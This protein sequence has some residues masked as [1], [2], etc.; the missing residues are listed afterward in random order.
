MV[1]VPQ[2]AVARQEVI[3][4]VEYIDETDFSGDENDWEEEVFEIVEEVFPRQRSHWTVA[5]HEVGIGVP[6]LPSSSSSSSSSS[7]ISFRSDVRSVENDEI[8]KPSQQQQ[9]SLSFRGEGIPFSSQT[10]SEDFE[11]RLQRQ[12]DLIESTF[13][14]RRASLIKSRSA[15]PYMLRSNSMD[16]STAHVTPPNRK[17]LLKERSFVRRPKSYWYSDSDDDGDE[18]T[19]FAFTGDETFQAHLKIALGGE[20]TLAKPPESDDDQSS[21]FST[22]SGDTNP[23][24]APYT[25]REYMYAICTGVL[26]SFNAG[27]VN[28]TCL[29]G[30]LTESKRK[31]NVT[32]H[33]GTLTLSATSLSAGD[34]P[35]FS[36]YTSMMFCF[37]LGSYIAGLLTPNAKKFRI[38]PTY[39]PTFLIGAALLG[40]SSILAAIE[41]NDNVIFYLASAANGIQNGMSSLYSANLIRS[42]GVTGTVTDIGI[43][44]GQMLRGNKKN[45]WN[46]VVLLCLFMSFWTGGFVSFYATNKF[47][48]FSL[49]VNA[50]LYFLIG[51]SLIFFLTLELDVSVG[52]AIF[53]SWQ[54]RRALEQLRK[55]AF[56]ESQRSGLK[57]D[58][59]SSREAQMDMLFDRMD[60]NRS[61]TIDIHELHSALKLAGVRIT[62]RETMQ[63][64]KKADKNGDGEL[65]REEWRSIALLCHERHERERASR[66]L[67]GGI[68]MLSSD[69]DSSSRSGSSGDQDNHVYE[70][71]DART[72]NTS[73]DRFDNETNSNCQLKET[74]SEDM[75]ENENDSNSQLKTSS[76]EDRFDNE[77]IS[78]LRLQTSSSEDG[79]DNEN[80]SKH[81]LKTRSSKDGC[82]NEIIKENQLVQRSIVDDRLNEKSIEKTSSVDRFSNESG[83]ADPSFNETNGSN[84]VDIAHLRE[85]QLELAISEDRSD[86]EKKDDRGNELNK[87]S[88]DDQFDDNNSKGDNGAVPFYELPNFALD[89]NLSQ[90]GAKPTI[91]FQTRLLQLKEY[92]VKH[93]DF[94]VTPN[95]EFD[96]GFFVWFM[97]VTSEFSKKKHGEGDMSDDLFGELQK[98]GFR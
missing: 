15:G 36:F 87:S 28:G 23:L 27:Y 86:I 41:A 2:T 18:S 44:L 57:G 39:G 4:V 40:A 69:N 35:E 97:F 91:S 79:F 72:E 14:P 73:E 94:E 80:N 53:G 50:G 20:E 17:S 42:T 60:S 38:E 34:I 54:W 47:T 21:L 32:S 7:L 75:F 70:D 43:F 49:L 45:T 67:I 30:L 46:L 61:G 25:R 33:A 1:V 63:M 6:P 31:V 48:Q 64:I 88:C 11:D 92:K 93:G 85:G 9:E 51:A 81:H 37:M 76:S 55:D 29:T 98:I 13:K 16:D 96:E 65:S 77:C 52:A 84:L 90:Q 12:S 26:L 83:S 3:E 71:D 10:D 5:A 56:S 74:H 8:E 24:G 22:R 58:H 66:S 78:A 95:N 82:D 59:C 68:D 19:S 62:K 89:L